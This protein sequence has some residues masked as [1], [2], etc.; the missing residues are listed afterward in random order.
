[1]VYNRLLPILNQSQTNEQ[2]G[3]RPGLR[4]DDAL[5]IAES[6]FSKCSEFNIPIWMA[7]L[8]LKKAFDRVSYSAIFEALRSQGIDE[9]MIA[10][11]LDLYS[12]QSG[13]TRGGKAFPI[14][15]GVRQ[16]D[17]I[18][19][20]IFNAV[21]EYAFQSWKNKL[22]DHGWLLSNEALERL[23]NSRYADDMRYF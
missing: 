15:R 17:I 6:M 8:D 20:I 14:R 18:S 13:S 23:T 19:S 7:S 3:F 16:G 12:M 2:C 5:V 22:G 10:L 21:L 4:I 11:L 9:P 1:M